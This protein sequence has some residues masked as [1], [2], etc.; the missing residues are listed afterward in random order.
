LRANRAYRVGGWNTGHL[1]VHQ[2]DVGAQPVRRSAPP[3]RRRLR[4]RSAATR[5]RR[6]RA[7]ALAHDCVI[8]DQGTRIVA[9]MILTV[10]GVAACSH[11]SPVTAGS[12]LSREIPA[13]SDKK[14]RARPGPRDI[15][16]RRAAMRVW[17]QSR[18][19]P[20]SV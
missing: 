4:R 1:E 19:F 7:R 18:A 13:V 3:C 5:C 12:A 11:G 8:V 20:G 15:A 14:A 10:S 17:T 9:L 16:A 2:H 6:Q